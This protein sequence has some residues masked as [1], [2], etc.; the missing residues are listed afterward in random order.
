MRKTILLLAGIFC[1]KGIFAANPS[2]TALADYR[3][4]PLPAEISIQQNPPFVL[5]NQVQVIFP[6]KNEKMKGNALFL[7]QYLKSL[8]G[9]DIQAKKGNCGKNAIILSLGLQSTNPEAYQL[10]VTSKNVIIKGVTEAGVFY[11]IQT[12]RKSIPVSTSAKIDLPAVVINDSP[13]FK[14]RGMHLDV[15]RHF[16]TV[17]EVKRY[18]DILALHNVNNFH[19]HLTDD[20]GWRVE[21]KK[22]PLLTEIGSKRPETVIGK[23]SGKYDGIPHEGF[24][25]Q[26]QI[27]EI[28]AYA[29]D[30]YINVIP[31]IDMPGHMLGALS[32]Y[33]DMGCT[34]GPYAIW[35]I[36]GVSSE[37]LC[38]GN[39]KTLTFIKD[40]LTEITELFPSKYIHVGGDEC[41][42]TS[43]EKCPKCQARIQSLGLKADASHTAEERL[44]SYV[45][46]YAEK[47]LN[48]KGRKMI[49]WDEI[50]EG[51]LAPNATVMSWRGMGGGIEAAK[52]KHDVI[53]TP[54]SNLYFDHYQTND[55]SNEPFAIGGYSPVKSVYNFEPQPASLTS[56]EKNYII[57]TQA[58]VWTE[59]IP[60]FKH[61]EYMV[62]P[63]LAALCEV[64]W[65]K[66]EKKNY[67]DFLTRIPGMINQYKVNGYNYA[68]HLFEITA[69]YSSN[70]KEGCLDVV[71]STVDNAPIH[72][73]LDGTTPTPASPVYTNTLKICD[74]A[75]LNAIIFRGDEKSRL[76]TEKIAFNKASMKPIKALQPINNKYLYMGAP[77]LVDGLTGNAN[78]RTGRWIGFHKNDMDM[79]ID[80]ENDK[81]IEQMA[82]NTCVNKGDGVFDIRSLSVEI[83]N[84]GVN[85]T[86]IASENYPVMKQEDTNGTYTHKLSFS[87]VSTRYVRVIATPEASIPEWHGSKGSPAFIFVDEISLR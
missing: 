58:N 71:L 60:N 62:L 82:I 53:M 4:I 25:T 3:V 84:D 40:I 41:P 56:E 49:G 87:P 5:D 9:M 64:Q 51:G 35:R 74:N 16:F 75:N 37:V 11:G 76:L 30:R 28:V 6:K 47:I 26:A 54:S 14:Y 15:S 27:K 67:D 21:I 70:I 80:L 48:E 50:L 22:Y 39:D 2:G 23:N 55:I 7:S 36:W 32:A 69:D 19:W 44:Q 77:T 13:R 59:Y 42:K 8:T 18:I 73:T 31:E 12:L 43:W 29:K 78:F 63:R 61:V 81:T 79:V 72:Y 65:T 17:E 10:T 83:S 1:L 24:Y 85:F 20:Q 57:G 68:K 52:Q 86:R 33:P 45:I 46:S 34:G 38:I 66:V